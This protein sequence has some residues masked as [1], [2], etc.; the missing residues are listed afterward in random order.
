ALHA[1]EGYAI[2]PPWLPQDTPTL[3]LY[4][5]YEEDARP[6]SQ[7][8]PAP[9]QLVP[10]RPAYG[11]S[12]DGRDD[13]KQGLRSL[14]VRGE[15]LPLRLGGRDGNTSDSPETPGALDE[16]LALGRDGGRGIV[17]DRKAYCQRTLGVCL[18]QHV[19]LLTLVPRPCAVRQA[20]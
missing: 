20:L 9:E 5:A 11:H 4:G 7:S 6:A 1:L 19:G 10:P 8:Q 13:L 18:E 15:G 2:A 3:T 14:G 12:K 17:A 16:C